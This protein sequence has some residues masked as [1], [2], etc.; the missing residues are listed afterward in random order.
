M[1][2]IYTLLC[3]LLCTS[4]CINYVIMSNKYHSELI[5]GRPDFELSQIA[6]WFRTVIII[7]I[8]IIV[9]IIIIIK[10][11]SVS[12]YLSLLSTSSYLLTLNTHRF[13][14]IYSLTRRFLFLS[15][16]IF[17]SPICIISYKELAILI[18]AS[19]I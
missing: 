12:N 9:I 15:K 13:H 17:V 19:I 8:I 16:R 3:T 6:I 18:E 1:L 11:I 5:L 4:L 2:V 7:I 10:E 14:R